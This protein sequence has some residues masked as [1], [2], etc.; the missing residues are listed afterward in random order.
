[1]KGEYLYNAMICVK[2]NNNNKLLESV[3]RNTEP[4]HCSNKAA[5]LYRLSI[6]EQSAGMQ[7]LLSSEIDQVQNCSGD[8]QRNISY[9]SKWHLL[10]FPLSISD[11]CARVLYRELL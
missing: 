8:T 3:S 5:D 6:L 2:V 11:I 10:N 4:Y 9:L 1:M 7:L